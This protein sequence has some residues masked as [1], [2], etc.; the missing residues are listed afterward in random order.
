MYP[1][2][3]H[4]QAQISKQQYM[5]EITRILEINLLVESAFYRMRNAK[6][7]THREQEMHEN[8]LTMQIQNAGLV[9][10][11][12]QTSGGFEFFKKNIFQKEEIC[13]EYTKLLKYVSEHPY[14]QPPPDLYK[15]IKWENP[16]EFNAKDMNTAMYHLAQG[17]NNEDERK[18]F[19]SQNQMATEEDWHKYQKENL[20]HKT[21]PNSKTEEEKSSPMKDIDGIHENLPTKPSWEIFKEKDMVKYSSKIKKLGYTKYFGQYKEDIFCEFEDQLKSYSEKYKQIKKEYQ[22]PPGIHTIH[23]YAEFFP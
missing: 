22:L 23:Y 20:G 17:M 18:K 13:P 11:D 5:V 6:T 3:M 12:I 9:F 7:L 4:I 14:Q 15:E 21:Y 10:G 1:N 2:Q 16:V 19:F 8:N